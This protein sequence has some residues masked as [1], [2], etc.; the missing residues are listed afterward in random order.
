[1]KKYKI[2]LSLAFLLATIFILVKQE[3]AKAGSIEQIREAT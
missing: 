2:I 1:M 3:E